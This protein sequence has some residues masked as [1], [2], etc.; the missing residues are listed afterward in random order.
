MSKDQQEIEKRLKELKIEKIRRLR[1]DKHQ[2]YQPI[3]VVEKF[4][5]KW[6]S[7]DYFVGVLAGANGI[8]K[9]TVI[10]NI[11]RAICFETNNRYF[12]QKLFQSF[13]YPLKKGRIVSDP[14]TI[15]ETIIPALH[16]WLPQMRYK[17]LKKS[18][19][20][21]YTWVT[22]TGWEFDLMTYDQQ[23]KEFESANLS[24]CLFDEPPPKSK[25][26][27]SVARMRQGGILGIFMTPLTGSA[28]IYDDIISSKSNEEGE[29]FFMTTKVEDACIDH[30]IRGFL[31][32]DDIMR[33]VKQ[34]DPDDMQARVFGKFQHLTGLIFKKW[35]RNIHVVEPFDI[36]HEDFVVVEAL[37]VHPRNPDALMYVAI[38]RKGR[39]FVFDEYFEN[40]STSQL[41]S[42]IKAKRSAYRVVASFIDPSAFNEDQHKKGSGG[43]YASLSAELQY[44]YGVHFLPGSKRRAD[45]IKSVKGMLDYQQIGTEF[46]K[47]P[48][49]YVFS[50]C[51]RTIYEIEHWQWQEWNSSTGER[52]NPKEAPIDKDDHMMENL[53]RIVLANVKYTE[54]SLRVGSLSNITN[55]D[56]YG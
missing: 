6:A 30:G 15:K 24:W 49:L 53:G 9:T 55:D 1:M 18:K 45:A 31:K 12:Q 16:E 22:D 5:D 34:Y 8:G 50:S 38:D 35:D 36:N 46:V 56:P 51:V 11:V 26:K 29:R 52:K 10:A 21:E 27:A 40:N 54:P 7:C 44:K 43:G 4:L 13:P 2:F 48:M 19:P 37:D 25:Y 28:W 42:V 23:D 33:M 32:H 47:A 41:V 39:H 17:T 14:T 20:Y 3:G